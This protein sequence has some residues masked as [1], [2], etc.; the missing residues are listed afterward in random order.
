MLHEQL[1]QIARKS[2]E[3]QLEHQKTIEQ[4][5]L[6]EQYPELKKKR[7]TFVTLTIHGELRGC[8]GSIMPHQSLLDDIV[9]NAASAAFKDPRFF[10]L[11]KEEY[12][13]STVEVSLLTPPE[14][15]TYEDV[16]DLKSKIRPGIDGVIIQKGGYSATFLPQVWE[17]LPTF[18][19]FFAHLGQKAGLGSDVLELHPQVQ[20]YQVENFEDAPLRDRS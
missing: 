16:H 5:D 2:I 4:I 18:E 10:P 19:L 17:Q 11:T 7:A 12:L 8:I 3:D 15:L 6:L 14:E 1:L 20:T 13:Q 9:H